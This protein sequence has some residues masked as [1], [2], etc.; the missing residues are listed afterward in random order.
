VLGQRIRLDIDE[1][2]TEDEDTPG[3]WMRIVG[4]SPTVRQT[5]VQE[6][7]EGFSGKRPPP[8]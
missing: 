5:A 7:G 8:D 4:V 2:E 3:S 1:D 6:T